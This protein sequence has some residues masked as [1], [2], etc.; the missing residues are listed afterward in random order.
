MSAAVLESYSEQNYW[1]ITSKFFIWKINNISCKKDI[2]SFVLVI[3][4][5]PTN[6][7]SR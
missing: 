2:C 3:S 7:T 4:Q 1:V 6:Q 5:T